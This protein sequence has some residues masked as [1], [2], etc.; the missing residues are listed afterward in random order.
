ME[1]VFSLVT[2]GGVEWVASAAL[3]AEIGRNPEADH[4]AQELSLLPKASNS[5]RPDGMTYARAQVLE[6]A[7]YRIYD[8]LHLAC[9]EQA[10]AAFS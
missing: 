3:E 2:L 1:I 4:R 9:A 7:G 10:G 5:M 6:K 8:A